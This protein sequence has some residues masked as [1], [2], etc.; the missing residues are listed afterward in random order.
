MTERITVTI[1]T[2]SWASG[3]LSSGRSHLILK[4]AGSPGN[5]QRLFRRFLMPF[6]TM[7]NFH[8]RVLA[9]AQDEV[10]RYSDITNRCDQPSRLRISRTKVTVR[11][12]SC[13]RH[14]DKP[15]L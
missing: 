5:G 15:R 10:T 1:L 2:E 12:S 11:A 7:C 8:P 9:Y 4:T 14:G 6:T 3:G 13:S